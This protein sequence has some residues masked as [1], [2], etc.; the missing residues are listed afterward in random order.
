M[1]SDPPFEGKTG[2]REDG[3]MGRREDGKAGRGEEC[4]LYL[5]IFAVG[6]LSEPEWRA[7]FPELVPTLLRGNAAEDAL[8]P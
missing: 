7:A 2:K 5:R 4:R 6:G 1:G 8:R 3:K